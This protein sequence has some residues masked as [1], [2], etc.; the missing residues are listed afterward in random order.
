MEFE[1]NEIANTSLVSSLL[2]LQEFQSWNTKAKRW[3]ENLKCLTTNRADSNRLELSSKPSKGRD[4]NKYVAV[5]WSWRY[6]PGLEKRASGNYTIYDPDR[7]IAR[8]NKTRDEVLQ[9]VLKYAEHERVRR[10]WIDKDCVDKSN[11]KEHEVAMNSMDLV[12][13]NSEHPVGLI[14][15]VLKTQEEVNI[16]QDLLRGEFIRKF[17]DDDQ[18]PKLAHTVCNARSLRLLRL[19]KRLAADRWWHR[20]WIFQEGYLSS[21]NM[22]LLIRHRPWLNKYSRFG[23]IPDEMCISASFLREQA[24]RFLLAYRKQGKQSLRNTCTSLL[25]TFGKYNILY[26]FT[27]D[28]SCRAMSSRV[29]ADIIGRGIEHKFDVLP[30]AA[31]SCNYPIRFDSSEMRESGCRLEFCALAM[32]LLNGEIIRDANRIIKM[33]SDLTLSKYLRYISL[34]SFDPPVSGKELSF[35]KNCRLSNVSLCALGVFTNGHLWEVCTIFDTKEWVTP[36]RLSEKHLGNGLTDF[37]RDSLY[38]LAS[39]LWDED[40][41]RYG[42][43][44]SK[45]RNYL[46]EDNADRTL[47]R[48]PSREYMDL[49]A[50]EVVE[51]I[52][53]GNHLYVASTCES[54]QASGIFV[55]LRGRHARAFTSWSMQEG[56]NGREQM[57]HVSLEIQ[58]DVEIGAPQVRTIKWANGLVFFKQRKQKQVIFSWPHTWKVKTGQ[59]QAKTS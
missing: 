30:I 25:K 18:H 42:S 48:S 2:R 59:G 12:Y 45:L 52:R 40:C 41:R 32:Y 8:K 3:A 24:T 46:T 38:Q 9:R 47:L 11:K 7:K 6:T 34:D 10:V 44:A 16:L 37:Q 4:R 33:P 13:S 56:S 26:R 23:T 21:I 35:L 19:L 36:P 58:V 20:A 49:M 15:A 43:L 54:D 53:M 55:G 51:A 17:D 22:I 50:E 27:Q 28:A 39:K 29:F 5:S 1:R 57:R 31:N 14:T